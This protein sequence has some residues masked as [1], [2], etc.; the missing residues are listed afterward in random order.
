[1]RLF[2]IAFVL[3]FCFFR[4][5]F[6][7]DLEKKRAALI[8]IAEQLI[9]TPYKNSKNSGFDCSGFVQHCYN[10]L[11]IPIPRSSRAQFAAGSKISPEEAEPGDIIVFTGRNS[12]S[13]KAGH[14]GIIH[15]I[16]QDTI[17]FIHSSSSRGVIKSHS[18][19]AYYSKRFMGIVH[20]IN[21][22]YLSILPFYS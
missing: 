20:F 4:P 3:V 16:Q 15:K 13:G 12:N 10:E 6:E 21:N 11:G 17:H 19:Q 1:M 14:V 2:G 7:S 18:K 9:G 22:K 8:D 5:D